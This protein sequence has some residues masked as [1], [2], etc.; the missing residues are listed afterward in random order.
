MAAG[1]LR[2]HIVRVMAE[3]R[4]RPM[5]LALVRE[6]L[7]PEEVYEK[8]PPRGRRSGPG[9]ERGPEPVRRGPVCG[10]GGGRVGAW[11][12]KGSGAGAAGPVCGAA[13]DL[14]WV[15][16]LPAPLPAL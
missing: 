5:D 4:E 15:R 6:Y 10:G 12:G 1:S 7:E 11:A 3:H 8:R 14:P 2:P 16:H 9:R 13:G